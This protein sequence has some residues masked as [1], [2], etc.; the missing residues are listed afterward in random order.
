[1]YFLLRSII[2]G[3][4]QGHARVGD[5]RGTGA[6]VRERGRGLPR[7]GGPS[8]DVVPET[9]PTSPEEPSVCHTEVKKY[10]SQVCSEESLWKG[11]LGGVYGTRVSMRRRKRRKKKE[12]HRLRVR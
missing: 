11:L 2:K 5:R 7:R 4:D 12:K 3:L 6:R 1:M 8:E 9:R 10:Q